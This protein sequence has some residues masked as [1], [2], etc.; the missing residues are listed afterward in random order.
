MSKHGN[1]A[2]LSLV[3]GALLFAGC[4]P[5]SPTGD[6]IQ[7]GDGGQS[8]DG[9][10][11]GDG[12]QTG[13]GSHPSAEV[14]PAGT[15]LRF[16]LG[17]G[18]VGY[19]D[20]LDISDDRIIRL[21]IH[22]KLASATRLTAKEAESLDSLRARSGRINLEHTP[23]PDTRDGVGSS[24]LFDGKGSAPLDPEVRDLAETLH[25]RM[26]LLS[27]V[28]QSTIVVVGRARDL[29]QGSPAPPGVQITVE[30][31]LKQPDALGL[32]A[33]AVIKLASG[34]GISQKSLGPQVCW[35]VD[36]NAAREKDGSWHG[37]YARSTDLQEATVAEAV[38]E[39]RE[40]TPAP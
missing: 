14:L 4:K 2:A 16:R 20:R 3:L 12:G 28:W 11:S 26:R 7:T 18:M 31:V 23:R 32:R 35:F 34:S 21:H 27:G 9:G 24:I 1:C 5:G 8:G 19:A 25:Q 29:P 38:K 22:D 10:P 6:G 40:L 15:I 13:D 33:G 39:Q 36:P 17:G 30:R 37:Q